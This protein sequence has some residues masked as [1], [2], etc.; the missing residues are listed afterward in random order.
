MTDE[1][2]RRYLAAKRALFRKYY[3]ERLNP[4]QCD[5]VLTAKGP[6]LILAGAGSGKTTVLVNRI[7]HIVKYGTAYE[8]DYVPAHVTEED[9]AAMEAALYLSAR[10]LEPLLSAFIHHACPPWAMLAITFTNKAANEIKERLLSALGE[11]EAVKDIWAGTFHSVCMRILRRYHDRAGLPEGFSI[12]DTQDK[13]RLVSEVMKDLN[14]DDKILPIR[15]VMTAISHEKDNLRTPRDMAEGKDLRGRHMHRIYEAYQER[16]EKNGA[17]DF[18]DII[19]KTVK[20]L[21]KDEEV[22][23]YYQ[24]KFSYICVDE[25]Q[26]TNPAQ[27]RLC[28]ILAEGHRN[29]MVVGDDD[30]SIYKFRGATIENILQFDTVYPDAKVVKLEQ[31]YRSTKTILAAAN[32][33]IARNTD[34]HDKALW[35]NGAEGE[36]ITVHTAE[37]GDRECRYIID[38][39]LKLVVT[40]KR[41]YSD[42]A[43]LYRVNEIS[44]HLETTFAKSGIPHRILGGMR[45]YDR[46]EIKDILAYLYLILNHADDG[47]LLRIVN[48]PKRKIG[49]KTMETVAA[50]AEEEGRS[51]FDVMARAAE[52]PALAKSAE[53]LRAFTTLIESFDPTLLRPSAL[54][55]LVMEKT[56]Y[57]DMLRA[58]GEAMKSDLDNLAELVSAAVEYEEKNDEPT[59]LGFLED[60]ALVSDIDKYDDEAE[61]V[62]LMTIHSA[63]GLEFPVVFLAGAEEGIFPGNASISNPEE[64]SE[65]RRLAYV[66]ITRAKEKL[67]VTSASERLLYGTTQYHRPSRFIADEVPDHLKEKTSPARPA[68]GAE[69]PAFSSPAHRPAPAP[70]N[71][72]FARRPAASAT[73]S[74]AS[75]RRS[76]AFAAGDRVK[77]LLFG[78]GTIT[79]VRPMGGDTLYEI[80]FDNGQVK[81]LMATYAKLQKL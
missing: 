11:E 72:E 28:A 8:T 40:Q 77:H 70:Q 46:K 54:L 48:E 68:F 52:Y 6:L 50:I 10:E 17:V 71:G 38:T 4:E 15:S 47:R 79:A 25:Y 19:M 61:A 12:Y 36:R 33:V 22:R 62:V 66:A 35:C 59:L 13:K 24:G 5:A 41:K 78:T 27:F 58:G 74:T 32:A 63:K 39:I 55:P 34:R 7:C 51:C 75:P 49:D 80:R 31:N 30:Q 76:A 16:L 2:K 53:K 43:I 65:E 18:D 37:T 23:A 29:I 3:G 44:R 81:K 67:F 20:L 60:A 42:F 9:I 56:G 64:M 1:I 69:R 45:F 14:I 26:D 57:M 21:E 73:A